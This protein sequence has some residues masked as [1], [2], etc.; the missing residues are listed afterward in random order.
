[1]R[2]PTTGRGVLPGLLLALGA[3]TCLPT[4][5]WA[6]ATRAPA[7]ARTAA[8]TAGAAAGPKEGTAIVA[9]VNGEVITQGDLEHRRRLFALSTGQPVTQDVLAR[10]TPQ[11]IQQLVDER[12]R[13][14]EAQRRKIVVGDKEIFDAITEIE[15]RNGM[16]PGMLR[17]RLAS[18][19]VE[20]RTL[21]D[22]VRVQIGWGRVLREVLGEKTTVSD[23][24][25]KQEE[26]LLKSE[27]G[28]PE[29]RA[30]EIFVPISDPAKGEDARRFADT[31]I[32]QLRA[33]APFAVMAAQFSQSQ[34]ALSGGD[35]GWVQRSQLDPAVLRVLNEMPPGAVSNPI[36]VPGGLSIVTLRAKREVGHE[37][38]TM[39]QVRQVFFKFPT[40]LDPVAPTPQ[41]RQI[42]DDARRIAGGIKDCAGMEAAAKA[43]GDPKGGDPGEIRLETVGVPALRQLMATLP[44]GKVSQPLI[45]D[46]GVAEMMICAR[47]EKNLGVPTRKE[48]TDLIL[49]QRVELA[50]RQ[51]MRDLER[52]AL[53]DR[54]S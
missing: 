10:L 52:R 34:T 41:Q 12:L 7:P 13:L 18:Q 46:D 33:G 17:Q 42:I 37:P 15:T 47:E 49:N 16:P 14:Q 53:I 38:A 51:L 2:L 28:Q 26:D 29:Y 8:A 9:V 21:I 45:A 23:A 50:S 54:R 24:D 27:T 6:Q 35:L 43:A 22:Q 3:A 31:I 36:P 39:V 20:L 44:L 30:G 32:E 40:K 1:M 11:V 5:G 25:L 48:M 19:G 4:A